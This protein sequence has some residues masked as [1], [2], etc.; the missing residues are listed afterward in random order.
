MT[1]SAQAYAYEAGA[2]ELG[3][4]YLARRRP[5]PLLNVCIR[6]GHVSTSV[7]FENFYRSSRWSSRSW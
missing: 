5:V 6:L 4:A 3:D 2:S 7:N 1:K